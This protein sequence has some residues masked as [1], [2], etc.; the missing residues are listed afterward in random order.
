MS[1]IAQKLKDVQ[2]RLKTLSANRD[3]VIREA[4]AEE[5]KLKEAH[6]KL[7]ELGVENS[8]EMSVEELKAM[9]DELKEKLTSKLEVLEQEL[10]SGETLMSQ[11]KE[12]KELLHG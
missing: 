9:A 4:G 3:Q 8:E 7:A 12:T 5:N 10:V 6:A 11:Y 2:T 1:E